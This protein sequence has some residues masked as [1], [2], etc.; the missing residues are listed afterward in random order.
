MHAYINGALANFEKSWRCFE[1][2]GVGMSRKEVKAVLTYAKLKGYE[3]TEQLKDE[4]VDSV[5]ES[6]KKHLR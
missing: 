1:H 6:L 3:S 5:L 2:K 4:E